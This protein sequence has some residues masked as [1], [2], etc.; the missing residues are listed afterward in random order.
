ME[1]RNDYERIDACFREIKKSLTTYLRRTDFS[2]L[3]CSEKAK[4]EIVTNVDKEIEA[5]LVGIVHKN[6]PDHGVV[7]EEGTYARG[8]GEHVWYI[9]PIDN[10]VGLVSG[11]K[12]VS[13]S[14]SLKN[15]SKHV[16]SMVM[17][18]RTKDIFEADRYGGF[19]NGKKIVPFKGTLSSK[20]R[21]ISTCGFV[22]P[23]NIERWNE[24]MDVILGARYP[25]RISGGAALDLCYVAAGT[26]AAH[27]SLGAHPWDIEA[28]LHIVEAAGGVV[29]ILQEFPE[30]NSVAFLASANRKVHKDIKKLVGSSIEY[31]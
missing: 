4:K 5:L 28:G 19:R 16:Y 14:I 1:T 26:H 11:E 2:A 7:G 9:D 8:S 15:K 21:P 12:D 25:I 27:I 10:T 13:T 20:T 3:R 31:I 23:I 30:R 22:N 18:V 29:E 6:F 17:N 24:L